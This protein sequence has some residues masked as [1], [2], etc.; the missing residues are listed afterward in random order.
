MSAL[1]ATCID[2][3]PDRATETWNRA[4]AIDPSDPEAR[5]MRAAFDL[6][7]GRGNFDKVVGQLRAIIERDPLSAIAHSQLSIILSFAVGS[8]KRSRKP[9]ALAMAG[10]RTAPEFSEILRGLGAVQ[11]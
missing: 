2:F 11:H 4:L 1:V 10:L 9:C 3:D 7:Y 6:C 8:M 5:V